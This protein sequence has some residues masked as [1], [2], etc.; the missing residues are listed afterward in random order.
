M[1][2]LMEDD[3]ISIGE[4]HTRLDE[5]PH[6]R[7]VGP[8]GTAALD[9]LKD[10]GQTRAGFRSGLIGAGVFELRVHC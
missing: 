8:I 2:L 1:L 5:A 10:D 4:V 6:D 9:F 3:F 7:L